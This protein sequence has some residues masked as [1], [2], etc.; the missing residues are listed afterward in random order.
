M[1]P[2]CGSRQLLVRGGRTWRAYLSAERDPDNGN[3]PTNARDRIGSGPW[4][5]A[6]GR[7]GRQHFWRSCTLAP[8]M[9]MCSWTSVASDIKRPMAWITDAERAR[10]L[11]GSTSEGNVMTGFNL[12]RTGHRRQQTCRR[13]GGAFRWAWRWRQHGR[14]P[15]RRGTRRTQVGAAPIRPRVAAPAVLYCFAR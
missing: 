1:R 14:A 3:R 5:N 11:T 6:A 4:I 15:S 2:A 13:R 12:Q 7:D 9:S 8:A 10:H